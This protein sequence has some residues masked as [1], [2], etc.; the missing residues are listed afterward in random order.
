ME[1]V[2]PTSWFV[3][4]PTAVLMVLVLV[5]FATLIKGADWLVEGASG[6]AYRFG[7]PK[8]VVGATIVS[9][10]TTSPEAAVSVMSAWNGNA[11]IALGNAVGSIIMDTGLIFGLCCMLTT[12][13]ADNFVLNRQG[14]VQFGSAVC[15]A[16]VCYVAYATHGD[17]AAIGRS[18][19]VVLL[20]AL[21]GYMLL[22][23]RWAKS[24]G[25]N[26]EEVAV[27]PT[28][29]I[30][31]MCVMMMAGL[32]VVIVSSHIVIESVIQLAERLSVP[33]VV[34]SATLVAAGTSLPELVVG[35]TSIRKGH[36]ELLVGNVIGA[37]I[38]NVL[39]VVGASAVAA[40][41]PLVEVSPDPSQP[42]SYLF[43]TLQLP[44]MLV[45]LALF[46]MMILTA[47]RRGHFMRWNG[48]PLLMVYVAFVVLS[49]VLGR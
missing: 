14:W 27:D 8:V 23:V 44:V 31:A 3:A 4:L 43:L 30:V 13:P 9:L 1:H 40:S 17:S 37:D 19:G 15:L 41:L 32:A 7:L 24:R 48:L 38:L 5:F 49:A 2:I 22:S 11:G 35:I 26:F 16:L 21:V 28:H 10:G 47:T 34:I 25:Q 45:I 39:F 46:R 33:Q 42:P 6:I 29:S 20:L 18:V 36:P 12:L